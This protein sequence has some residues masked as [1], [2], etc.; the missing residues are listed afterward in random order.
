MTTRFLAFD[1]EIAK[2]LPDGTTDWW[3][4]APLGISCAAIAHMDHDEVVTHTW[5][6]VPQMTRDE[7]CEMVGDLTDAVDAG[8][9]LVTWNG[10]SFDWRV[11]ALESGLHAE[12]R[13]LAL[14]HVDPM[15]QVHCL[16]GFPIGL[17]AVCQG[18]RLPGKP[19]GMSGE[20]APALWQAGEYETVLKYVQQDV[21]CTLAVA[22]EIEQ[23][24]D[25]Q[26]VAR[27]GRLNYLPIPKLLTVKEA[28]QLPE[29]N[30]SW[31]TEPIPRS[32]FTQWMDGNAAA[33]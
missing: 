13:E 6:G 4:H 3:A 7:C 17:D 24:R 11:A 10:L 33:A 23:R 9:T 12:C 31:M 25:L 16:R 21:R 5:N 26:W 27:S 1:L 28:M 29:P 14:S 32:K 18:M 22:L 19:E 30:T 8:Y 20:K 2:C 15:F